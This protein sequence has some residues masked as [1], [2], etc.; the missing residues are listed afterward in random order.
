MCIIES[1]G[2]LRYNLMEPSVSPSEFLATHLYAPKSSISTSTIVNFITTLYTFSK[3]S[4]TYLLPRM[5]TQQIQNR[6][7]EIEFSTQNA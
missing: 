5:Q 1:G 2:Y 3:T 4:C 6:F 7:S